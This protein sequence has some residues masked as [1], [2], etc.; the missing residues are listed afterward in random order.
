MAGTTLGSHP[1][2]SSRTSGNETIVATSVEDT[3]SLRDDWIAVLARYG[4]ETLDSAPEFFLPFLTGLGDIT[5]PHVAVFRRDGVPSAVIVGR[6][7]LRNIPCHIGHLKFRTPRLR[8]LDIVHGGLV[9]DGHQTSIRWV[10]THLK[11][12]LES[13][14]VEHIAINHLSVDDPVLDETIYPSI[15]HHV[16][17]SQNEPHWYATL[18]DPKT[19]EAVDTHSSKTLRTFRRKDKKLLEH[20]NQQVNIE[21]VDGVSGKDLFLERACSIAARTYQSAIGVGFADNPRWRT[22]LDTLAVNGYL[23]G[24]VLIAAGEP[25]AYVFGSVFRSVFTLIATAFIPKHRDIGPGAYLL[26]HVLRVLADQGVSTVDFG[27]GDAAYKRL[28]GT[29][30]RSDVNLVFY[31]SGPKVRLA[32]YMIAG[33][34]LLLR[35]IGYLLRRTGTFDRIKKAWRLRLG[36]RD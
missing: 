13:G 5:Q 2:P 21:T 3:D 14:Q 24:Y 30:C 20:F 32:Q 1:S 16:L 19:G 17:L 36:A 28:H 29:E 26:R 31:G 18:L 4:K 11:Q 33:R 7:A 12:L 27:F 6:T 22:M 9:S 35:L 34:G 15:S 23:R 25:I 8:C 10:T